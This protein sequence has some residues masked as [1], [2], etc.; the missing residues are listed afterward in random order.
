MVQKKM[1]RP[2]KVVNQ[3]KFYLNNRR[4]DCKSKGKLEDHL[5]FKIYSLSGTINYG[6]HG[7]ERF[8]GL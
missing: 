1:E 2:A 8:G 7:L 5:Y 6:T 3:S 4:I